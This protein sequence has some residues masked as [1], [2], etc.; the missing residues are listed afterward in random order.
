MKV[1]LIKN[2]KGNPI[3]WTMDV[4]SPQEQEIL[5]TIRDLQFFGMDDTSIKYDGRTDYDDNN[6]ICGKLHWKQKKYLTK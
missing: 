1:E 3:G 2:K 6:H 4:E 5:N